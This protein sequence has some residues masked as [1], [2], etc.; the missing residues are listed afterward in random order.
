M[1]RLL[2]FALFLVGIAFAPA[3]PGLRSAPAADRAG[4]ARDAVRVPAGRLLDLTHDI[5]ENSPVFFASM[6]FHAEQDPTEAQHNIY[7]RTFKASEH[8][9]THVD[10]PDHFGGKNQASIDQLTLRQLLLPAAVVDVS[11][12]VKGNADYQLSVADLDAW[13]KRNGKIPAGSIVIARTGWEARWAR[14]EPYRNADAKGALHFPGFSVAAAERLV[15]RKVA[16]LGIDTLSVD[17][18][19]STDFKVHYT[20]QPRGIYHIENLANLG[21]LPA[22]GATVLVSPL[23]LKGGSG[24]PAR[25]WAILP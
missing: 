5:S 11:A 7:S 10:A 23:K 14:G 19:P 3:I 12:S 13:E 17:Y 1:K 8:L 20:T 16:A 6:K 24:S 2:L 15:E 9:G 18:G 4:M 21:S 25:V 22:T